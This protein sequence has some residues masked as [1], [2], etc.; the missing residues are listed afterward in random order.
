MLVTG[1]WVPT[2][3]RRVPMVAGVMSW[4]RLS[5]ASDAQAAVVQYFK[6][7]PVDAVVHAAARAK[8]SQHVEV[9]HSAQRSQQQ[10]PLLTPSMQFQVAAFLHPED[11][12]TKDLTTKECQDMK[13]SVQAILS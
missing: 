2:Y 8:V 13:A 6:T 7:T 12:V 4:L 5:D 9:V 10:L 3:L 1:L 11:I